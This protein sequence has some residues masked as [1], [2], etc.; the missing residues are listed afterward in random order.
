MK[1]PKSLAKNLQSK[2]GFTLVEILVVIAII[3][4]LSM[5]VFA[6][7]SQVRANARDKERLA[8]LKQMQAAIEIY[9]N[10]NGRYPA[11][12]CGRSAGS[13]TGHGSTF[14]SCAIYIAGISDL[15]NPLPIDTTTTVNGYLYRVNAAGTAYKLMSY[16]VLENQTVTAT[17]EYGRYRTADGCTTA[18]TGAQ[19]K[20]LAVFKGT[21][22]AC[23]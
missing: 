19:A 17:S 1:N 23:W 20:T 11:P 10:V 2:K 14:G 21:E 9:G 6:S 18:M 13:W 5:V 12:G 3:G 15:M 4:L 8:N 22:A 16:N 7:V